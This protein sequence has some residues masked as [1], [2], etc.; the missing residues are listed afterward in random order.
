[1]AIDYIGGLQI[2]ALSPANLAQ[3]YSEKI[4]F[5]L[6]LEHEGGFYGSIETAGGSLHMSVIPTQN[7]FQFSKNISFTF[8]VNDFEDYVAGLK[9]KGLNP[10][11]EME[12]PNG[13]FAFFNDPEDN[14]IGIWG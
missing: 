12:T 4:G 13:K 2:E 3:W 7:P 1:M 6:T 11:Q 14:K 5:P 9:S 10:V 8:H